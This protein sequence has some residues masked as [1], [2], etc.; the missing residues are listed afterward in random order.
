MLERALRLQLV[1]VS[2]LSRAGGSLNVCGLDRNTTM[3]T[4]RSIVHP[5][6]SVDWLEVLRR[7]G[8]QCPGCGVK[9]LGVAI[10]RGLA[11]LEDTQ[12]QPFLAYFPPFDSHLPAS[13]FIDPQAA[14]LGVVNCSVCGDYRPATLEEARYA[15][16]EPQERA[17]EHGTNVG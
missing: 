16:F 13:L 15:L 8:K 2:M 6:E 1:V 10:N 9:R 3:E 11:L 4:R 12:T 7:H 17:M 5:T 14:E